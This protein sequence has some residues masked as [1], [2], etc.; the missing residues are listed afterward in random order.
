MVAQTYSPIEVIAVDHGSTDD[1][2]SI[3]RGLGALVISQHVGGLTGVY[4]SRGKFVALLDAD[5]WWA[6]KQLEWRV[7]AVSPT[8]LVYS[9][10]LFADSQGDSELRY[11]L[12]SVLTWPSPLWQPKRFATFVV[13]LRNQVRNRAYFC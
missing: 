10:V 7:A 3:V 6:S 9:G 1:T 8:V 11:L 2:A 5:D 4:H 13:T 12:R